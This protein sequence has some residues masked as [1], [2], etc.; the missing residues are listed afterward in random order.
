MIWLMN[1]AD[2][3]LYGVVFDLYL[4]GRFGHISNRSKACQAI[5]FKLKSENSNKGLYSAYFMVI[6]SSFWWLYF[7][8]N[9]QMIVLSKYLKQNF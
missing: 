9:N 8:N 1:E 2:K 4:C 7:K 5:S 6:Q 3:I